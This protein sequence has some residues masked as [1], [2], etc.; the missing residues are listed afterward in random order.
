MPSHDSHIYLFNQHLSLFQ[1]I[2]PID[3]TDEQT[4]IF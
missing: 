4:L 3:E 2:H 1:A